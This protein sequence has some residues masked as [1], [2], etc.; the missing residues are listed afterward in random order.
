M[1]S[2]RDIYQYIMQV[3][4]KDTGIGIPFVYSGT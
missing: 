4:Y 2:K 1:I 3:L